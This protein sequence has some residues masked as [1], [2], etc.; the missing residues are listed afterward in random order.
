M[1]I[2]ASQVWPLKYAC[3]VILSSSEDANLQSKINSQILSKSRAFRRKEYLMLSDH[4]I[5]QEWKSLLGWEGKKAD[6]REHERGLNLPSLA[7]KTEKWHHN[8]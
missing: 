6:G 1:F 8:Q 5:P 7:L 4:C 3:T 2:V